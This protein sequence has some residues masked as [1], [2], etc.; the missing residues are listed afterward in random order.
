MK[1][2]NRSVCQ[3]CRTRRLGC[4]GKRPECTQCVHSGRACDGYQ[5]SWTFVD[6]STSKSTLKQRKTGQVQ[7]FQTSSSLGQDDAQETIQKG[8]SSSLSLG[9]AQASFH[10]PSRDDF[11]TL[12]V[13]NY[14]PQDT[15]TAVHNDF[16]TKQPR[17]CGAWV[18]VLPNLRNGGGTPDLVLAAAVEAL[19]TSILTQKLNPNQD[20]VESFQS[21][22]VALRSLRKS[23]V[24]NQRC[25]IE[26]LASIMCLSLVELMMPSTSAALETHMKGAG[27]FFQAYG[28]EACSVGVLHTLFAG[29]RPLLI[30]EAFQFRKPT[31]LSSPA[32][33][34]APFSI[35]SASPMQSLL[36]K[37]A[38]IP[39]LLSQSDI[40]LDKARQSNLE[41]KDLFNSLVDALVDLE[42]WEMEYSHEADKWCYWPSDI[43]APLESI[44][45]GKP[46]WY[47][48]VTMANVYTN[49]WAFRIICFSELERLAENFPSFHMAHENIPLPRP[50][51]L[52]RVHAYK[53]ALAKQICL[54]MDYL[55]RDEMGLFGPASTYFPLQAA[56]ETFLENE[57][58]MRKEGIAFVEGVVLRLVQKGLRSAPVLVFTRRTMRV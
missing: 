2:K 54:S 50:L 25:D 14:V 51:N 40:L 29:F 53:T 32:W 43:P 27:Q 30:F 12:V 39:T 1:V 46:L 15:V 42:N 6:S 38:I 36:N 9:R 35:F 19:A 34:D 24:V 55:L 7:H 21:Y 48:N 41:V 3:T 44:S 45:Y 37:A 13:R 23:F 31:F 33:M 26:L 52:K 58:T 28:A 20:N 17:I 4:D 10:R 47:T 49:L 5:T 22:E 57:G 11:I 56:Y 16:R 18:E 8:L